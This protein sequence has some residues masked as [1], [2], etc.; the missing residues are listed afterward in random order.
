MNTQQTDDALPFI[1]CF[2]IDDKHYI[3]DVN[4]NEILRVESEDLARIVDALH[5]PQQ[6][7]RLLDHPNIRALMAEGYLSSHRPR[8]VRAPCR[9]RVEMG[10]KAEMAHCVLEL[11]QACNQ[12]CIYCPY[13]PLDTSRR[14]HSRK[15]M[16]WDTAKAAIDLLLNHSSAVEVPALGFYGGEPLLGWNLLQECLGYVRHRAGS[17]PLHMSITTNGTLVTD[18][19]AAVLAQY[20]VAVL[21]SLD[22]PEQRHNEFRRMKGMNR[23]DAFERTMR[24]L[25]RLRR[26]Y[27]R[28][29]ASKIMI[30]AVC[31]P[32]TMYNE[33]EEFFDQAPLPEIRDLPYRISS[34]SHPAVESLVAHCAPGD[35]PALDNSKEE[36][37]QRWHGALAN[38][39]VDVKNNSF[40][41]RMYEGPVL[42][43]HKRSRTF[44]P[45]FLGPMGM[46]IPGLRK[47]YV[48]VDG[49]ILPCE[50][51]SEQFVL[52]SVHE[53]GIDP[54]KCESMLTRIVDMIGTH[55]TQCVFCRL[56]CGCLVSYTDV[57][58][59]I[60]AKC[61]EQHCA[62]QTKECSDLL[63][64]YVEVLERN[65]KCLDYM[66]EIT[67]S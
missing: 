6:A 36:L 24:G 46:C 39:E 52:G 57:H 41:R 19:I 50:R 33:L 54:G 58:G 67:L 15:R 45:D 34:V 66:D 40:L 44:L 22:G 26:A 31:G 2:T 32:W 60:S 28:D 17:R 59:Q 18:D 62:R 21:V 16:S 3:Y 20:G 13:S 7:A 61:M 43:L 51:V 9:H 1:G 37:L 30:N 53:G 27:G 56:C 63:L 14:E 4:T 55:C 48:D 5:H 23:N 11:T 65:P 12:K 10:L 38:G 29:A 25:A 42:R 64:Q 8:G 49:N 35:S 47:F